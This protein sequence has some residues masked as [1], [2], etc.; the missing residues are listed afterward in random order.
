MQLVVLIF[1]N[2]LMFCIDGIGSPLFDRIGD[3]YLFTVRVDYIPFL[4]GTG[5]SR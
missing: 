2:V 5:R 1:L 4:C 3:L